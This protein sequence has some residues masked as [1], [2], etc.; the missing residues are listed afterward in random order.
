MP[1]CVCLLSHFTVSTGLQLDVARLSCRLQK[2]QTIPRVPL[3]PMRSWHRR[4]ES[5]RWYQTVL[6]RCCLA[7]LGPHVLHGV[8]YLDNAAACYSAGGCVLLR[9][10]RICRVCCR[11]ESET[12]GCQRE[13]GVAKLVSRT[14]V[15]ATGVL[16]SSRRVDLALLN[17]DHPSQEDLDTDDAARFVN[18]ILKESL[19][20]H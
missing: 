10:R 5:P 4:C 6:L 15:R 3:Y 17:L 19:T 2:K 12:Q 7:E 20:L 8:S 18:S 13:R 14:R 16:L 9:V 11:C 1:C